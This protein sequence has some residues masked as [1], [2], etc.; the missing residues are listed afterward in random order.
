MQQLSLSPENQ[1]F[2]SEQLASGQLHERRFSLAVARVI[3]GLLSPLPVET[4]DFKA[5]YIKT[6][7]PIYGPWLDKLNSLLPVDLFAVEELIENFY[8]YRFLQYA[9]KHT[10]LM[11]DTEEPLLTFFRIDICFAK[12]DLVLINQHAQ[13]LAPLMLKLGKLLKELNGSGE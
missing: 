12:D 10:P 4:E 13:V 1:K 7:K 8:R 6:I 11:G 3:A 9:E 5:G 2:I